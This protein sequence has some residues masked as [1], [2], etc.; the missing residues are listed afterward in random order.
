M[1][2]ILHIDS[3]ARIE[4]SATRAITADAVSALQKQYPEVKVIYRDLTKNPLP[5]IGPEFLAGIF[6]DGE[7]AS[8]ETVKLSDTLLGEL[9]AADILVIGTPMYNFSIP[10]QM[11][12]WID[13]VLR[14]GKTFSY[15]EQGPKGLVT[16]KRAIV[17]VASGGVYSEGPMVPFDHVGTLMKQVLSFIGITDVTV[18]RAEKQA[19]G[20]ELAGQELAHAKQEVEAAAKRA[21]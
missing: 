10:S 5:H 19:F 21:A 11:K 17:A 2:T 6:A 14:A 9:F 13:F 16:G 8:H 12:S 20:P 7:H 4:G 1:T 3:S 18:V 15:S